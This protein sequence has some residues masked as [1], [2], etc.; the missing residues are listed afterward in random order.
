VGRMVKGLFSR[1]VEDFAIELARELFKRCP[2]DKSGGNQSAM[3]VAKAV[4]DV[5]NRAAEFQREKRLGMYRKARLGTEFKMQ[6]REMGYES[7][8]VDEL[9]GRM[10]IKMSRTD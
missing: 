6:L 10:L 2:P 4:D 1:D 9:T 7:E 5:C 8:F 3:T